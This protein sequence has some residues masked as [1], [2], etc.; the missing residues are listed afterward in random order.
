MSHI[1]MIYKMLLCNLNVF[2]RIPHQ[3][4]FSAIGVIPA[5]LKTLMERNYQVVEKEE[6]DLHEQEE[7]IFDNDHNTIT[8]SG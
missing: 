7:D 2:K 8:V 5:Y 4:S 6:D 3:E 1:T